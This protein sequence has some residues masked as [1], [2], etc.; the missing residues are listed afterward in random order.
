[1]VALP[2]TFEEAFE[3]KTANV[4][5]ARE[6]LCRTCGGTGASEPGEMPTVRL[7]SCFGERRAVA[8]TLLYRPGHHPRNPHS[9]PATVVTI[10]T[11][12][13]IFARHRS[14]RNSIRRAKTA[15]VDYDT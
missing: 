7:T 5:V 11:H 8:F 10:N 12:L 1:M 9:P 4:T 3:G 13:T 15:A 2:V 6:R 14:E